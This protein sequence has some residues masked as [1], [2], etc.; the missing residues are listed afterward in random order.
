MT[1]RSV[2]ESVT[3]CASAA[4]A[5]YATG[6]RVHQCKLQKVRVKYAKLECGTWLAKAAVQSI[7]EISFHA[8]WPQAECERLT[9]CQQS[10]AGNTPSNGNG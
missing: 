9:N 8:R 2:T 5:R 7:V 4:L 3:F 6:L 1:L 10:L